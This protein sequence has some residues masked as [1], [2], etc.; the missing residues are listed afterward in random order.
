MAEF[1][2]KYPI[3]TRLRVNDAILESFKTQE[4]LDEFRLAMKADPNPD[5]LEAFQSKLDSK[6]EELVANL[7]SVP[8]RGLSTNKIDDVFDAGAQ[9]NAMMEVKKLM[10]GE[11]QQDAYYSPH[12]YDVII[13]SA[14]EGY[15]KVN[16]VAP[17]PEEGHSAPLPPPPKPKGVGL[18]G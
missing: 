4:G 10:A 17:A 16:G 2:D 9:R 11:V 15:L 5:K 14:K 8:D 7:D 13:E 6:R 1:V 3:E 18:G 12:H